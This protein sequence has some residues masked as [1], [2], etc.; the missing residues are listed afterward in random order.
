MHE[1]ITNGRDDAGG[2]YKSVKWRD[3]AKAGHYKMEG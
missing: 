1:D 2:R 3:G